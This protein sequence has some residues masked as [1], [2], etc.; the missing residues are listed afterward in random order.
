MSEFSIGDRVRYRRDCHQH[1]INHD[2][3]LRYAIGVV[4]DLRDLPGYGRAAFIDFG[5]FAPDHR[6]SGRRTSM[7]EK[8][9]D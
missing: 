3:D 4:I 9:S 7:F 2:Y 8:T 1:A 6:R 5:D